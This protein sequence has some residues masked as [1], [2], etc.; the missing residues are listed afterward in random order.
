MFQKR[1]YTIVPMTPSLNI[2]A[3]PFDKKHESFFIS[4][5][6]YHMHGLSFV[7][8]GSR[9]GVGCYGYGDCGYGLPYGCHGII[10]GGA[11]CGSGKV[12]AIWLLKLMHH[13]FP[14]ALC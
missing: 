7:C 6:S 13:G 8:V 9:C 4:H 3:A 14:D 11:V 1:R 2:T 12:G 10:N 5:K